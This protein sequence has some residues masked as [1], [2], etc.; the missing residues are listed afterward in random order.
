MNPT[1]L[2]QDAQTGLQAECKKADFS[3]WFVENDVEKVMC[4]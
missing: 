3:S 4:E 1:Q 2:V